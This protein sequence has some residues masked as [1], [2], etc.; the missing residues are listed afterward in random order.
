MKKRLLAIAMTL[1]MTLSLLPMSALAAEDGV[2]M[3]INSGASYE[4]DTPPERAERAVYKSLADAAKAVKTTKDTRSITRTRMKVSGRTP[5]RLSP[6][7]AVPSRVAMVR[8]AML[9]TT[10]PR[11]LR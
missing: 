6:S 10:S 4:N 3:Y 5:M 8:R 9:A 7:P 1:A 11:A 2:T